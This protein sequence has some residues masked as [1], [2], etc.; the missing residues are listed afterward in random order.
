M[1]LCTTIPWRPMA[2]GKYLHTTDVLVRICTRTKDDN[3]GRSRKANSG[4]HAEVT[5][6]D[7]DTSGQRSITRSG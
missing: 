5:K 6:V 7:R 3:M 1:D 2:G 4:A